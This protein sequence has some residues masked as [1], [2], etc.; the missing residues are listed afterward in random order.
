MCFKILKNI[1]FFFD[2]RPEINIMSTE[3]VILENLLLKKL[4]FLS[5][6]I[7]TEIPKPM[8]AI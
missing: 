1:T 6:V 2:I 4:K 5:A 8:D 3:V 7:H